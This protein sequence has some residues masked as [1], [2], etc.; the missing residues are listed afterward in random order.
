MKKSLLFLL[1][2]LMLF[3]AGCSSSSSGGASGDKDTLTIAW[4]PNES[5]ADLTEAR[6]EIGKIIEEKTGKKVKHQTTTDYIVAIEAVANGN[7]D[8]AFLGAQGYIE[9]HN[10]NDKVLPLVVPT[11]ASGTLDD[12]VYYSW[13]AAEKDNADQYKEGDGFAI[14]NIQGKKFSFV[15][16]SSTSGFKVPST[17][18]VDYFSEKA[19]FKDLTAED[20]LEG[21]D[22]NFFSEVLYG[23][24]HQGS[25]VNLLSGKADVAAFCDT[26]VNNYVELED[27]EENRPGAIYK[28]KTDAAEPFNT[29]TGKEFQL[30]SVT[31][32]LNAPFV[33]N[34][35]NISEDLQAQLLEVMTSDEITNNEKVFVPEDSEFS[36][37]FKKTA[38]ERLVEVKDEWF[39]PI[40]ELSK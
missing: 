14:D 16:N 19:E 23:G 1:S 31:P 39:N 35:D 34:T 13:L 18:I 32:V 9:A 5:G 30:I 10:K 7:A 37:L 22:G 2:L 26:C 20:L 11:G 25:A 28:V 36:G 29:V 12:A 3:V 40:R 21:G 24:S 38:D 6:D 8:M 4:L 27:G 17:G 15:S 33:V